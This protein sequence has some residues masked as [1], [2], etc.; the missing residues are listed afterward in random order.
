MVKLYYSFIKKQ[1]K[2]NFVK[3]VLSIFGETLSEIKEDNFK[4]GENYYSVSFSGDIIMVAVS[5]EKSVLS[6]ERVENVNYQLEAKNF[7]T[8]KEISKISRIEGYY[9]LLTKKQSMAKYFNAKLKDVTFED[10]IKLQGEIVKVKS[11][12]GLFDEYI[13][14]IASNEENYEKILIM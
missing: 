7:C 14:S 9:V 5:N 11:T 8:E 10:E 3:H 1:Q 4:Q 13:F 6:L 12:S 2:Q